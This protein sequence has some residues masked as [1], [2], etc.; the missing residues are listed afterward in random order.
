MK[1]GISRRSPN[2]F[3]L[4]RRQRLDSP[5]DESD[6]EIHTRDSEIRRLTGLGWSVEVAP[7]ASRSFNQSVLSCPER[8]VIRFNE[9]KRKT[10]HQSVHQE[11]ENSQTFLLRPYQC[12]GKLKI[13]RQK[14][15]DEWI[16]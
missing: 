8:C 10:E 5:A 1:N 14:E 4:R 15:M 9:E 13:Q 6:Q 3:V 2:R 16:A 11:T 12:F 7:V